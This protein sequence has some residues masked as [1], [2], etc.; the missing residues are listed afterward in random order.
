LKPA[1]PSRGPS[2]ELFFTLTL[3][4]L[5]EAAELAGAKVSLPPNAAPGDHTLFFSFV[6]EALVIL[7]EFTQQVLELTRLEDERREIILTHIKT[8][9]FTSDRGLLNRLRRVKKLEG[10]DMEE[11]FRIFELEAVTEEKNHA[12]RNGGFNRGRLGVD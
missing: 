8:F 4:W 9:E 7:V 10:K 1:G 11:I 12:I 6:R 3:L 2:G 5:F